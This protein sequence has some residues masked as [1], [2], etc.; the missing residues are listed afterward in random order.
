LQERKIDEGEEKKTSLQL[1][2]ELG[3]H[4]EGE[5]KKKRLVA[6]KPGGKLNLQKYFVTKS[7]RGG[8]RIDKS[9][10]EGKKLTK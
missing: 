4:M 8:H 10:L 5:P 3:L 7:L 1:F 6:G 2:S 9:E